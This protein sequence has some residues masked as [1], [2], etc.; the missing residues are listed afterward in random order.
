MFQFIGARIELKE[1]AHLKGSKE[2]VVTTE[3][4]SHVAFTKSNPEA[5]N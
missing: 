1:R 4:Y 2:P 5:I 3:S